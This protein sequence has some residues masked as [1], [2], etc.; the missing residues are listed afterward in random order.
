[1]HKNRK[2]SAFFCKKIWKYEKKVVILRHKLTLTHFFCYEQVQQMARRAPK[3]RVSGRN[4]DGGV[5]HHTLR[6]DVVL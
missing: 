6:T 2:K 5:H 4:F 3:N 1:M